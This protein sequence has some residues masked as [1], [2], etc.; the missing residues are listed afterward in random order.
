MIP[1]LRS[2]LRHK[3]NASSPGTYCIIHRPFSQSNSNNTID[4][5]STESSYGQ[6]NQER[7]LSRRISAC[8]I[9]SDGFRYDTPSSIRPN[10]R[11]P[12]TDIQSISNTQT[13]TTTVPTTTIPSHHDMSLNITHVDCGSLGPDRSRLISASC[14]VP[15]RKSGLPSLRRPPIPDFSVLSPASDEELVN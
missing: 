15:Y 2:H 11:A 6:S 12:R 1:F 8:M 14:H 5:I 7:Y 13:R 10:H 4:A 3:I 9:S